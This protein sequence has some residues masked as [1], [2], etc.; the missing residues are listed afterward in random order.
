MRILL[1]LIL[2]AALTVGSAYAFDRMQDTPNGSSAA[3]Q[4]HMVN[5]DVVDANWQTLKLR[6]RT[7]WN[8][9]AG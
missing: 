6:A 5:W 7:E 8:R 3:E 1:G 9:L 4:R 2:G